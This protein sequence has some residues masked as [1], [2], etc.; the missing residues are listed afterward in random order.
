MLSVAFGVSYKFQRYSIRPLSRNYKGNDTESLLAMS[1]YWPFM[2]HKK[3][4]NF[5]KY[6]AIYR[7]STRITENNNHVIK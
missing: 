1:I 2:Y 6:P 4:N 5:V 7:P 3:M